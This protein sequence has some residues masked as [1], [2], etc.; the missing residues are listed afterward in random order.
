MEDNS[1]ALP[2]DRDDLG[3]PE[4]EKAKG[5]GSHSEFFN[6][7]LD[8]IEEGK[9]MEVKLRLLGAT[10]IY[11]HCP[12]WTSMSEALNRPLTDLDFMALSKHNAKVEELFAKLSFQPNKHV[13][14]LYGRHRQIY[15]DPKNSRQVDI[16][17]DK[18]SFN[19]VLDLTKRLDID[20]VTI[21]LS[22][23]LLEK[24]QIVKMSEKDAKDVIVLL[25][26]HGVGDGLAGDI[27][28]KY[29]SKLLAGD[30][31]FIYTVYQFMTKVRDYLKGVNFV[32]PEDK[33]KVDGRM[34]E[35]MGK[36]DAQPKSLGW[37]M[38][39]SI[40]TKSLW[41]TEAEDVEH[42]Q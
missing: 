7:A 9:K 28:S 16:F 4:S 3:T 36:I 34:E 26:E 27:D 25:R 24:L 32:G 10:A 37:K 40:G 41:Y 11:Y 23:L 39:A 21:S 18:L 1:S 6:S 5:A 12:G 20:P 42:R 19:H 33:Q 17:F 29:V 14:M 31:G 38:R 2:K 30:W 35:L 8:I 15:Y 13:N 22:D